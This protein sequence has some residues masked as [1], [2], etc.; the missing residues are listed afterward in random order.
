[1]KLIHAK[2]SL[3]FKSY[4][5]ASNAAVTI[6]SVELSSHL[7]SLDVANLKNLLSLIV[8]LSL[9]VLFLCGLKKSKITDYGFSSIEKITYRYLPLGFLGR[10]CEHKRAF[11][12]S[13]SAVLTKNTQ[14]L[15]FPQKSTTQ[16]IFVDKL[17]KSISLILCLQMEFELK[18]LFW[19]CMNY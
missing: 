10:F 15:G 8:N 9:I 2:L 12:F 7:P 19:F 1:M 13:F 17:K 4:F 5:S 6:H 11:N 16:L 3:K 14:R 18:S